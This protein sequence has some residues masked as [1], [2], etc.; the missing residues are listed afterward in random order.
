METHIHIIVKLVQLPTPQGTQVGMQTMIKVEGARDDDLAYLLVA[1]EQA[2]RATQ[3]QVVQ[4][5][6][7]RVVVPGGAVG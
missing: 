7:P 4:Q 6:A 2:Q 1:L 5:A 3:Q